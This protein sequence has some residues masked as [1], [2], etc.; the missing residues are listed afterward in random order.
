MSGA[1]VTISGNSGPGPGG[2]PGGG[3]GG[4]GGSGGTNATESGNSTPPRPT[5]AWSL[6]NFLPSEAGCVSSQPGGGSNNPDSVGS[7]QNLNEND[8][9][10]SPLMPGSPLMIKNE[11]PP[12]EED[13][14]SNSS[15]NNET[16]FVKQEPYPSENSTS[17]PSGAGIP[18]ATPS[19]ALP[20]LNGESLPDFNK[21]GDIK[22][23]LDLSSPAK[24]PEKSPE[25]DSND[26]VDSVDENEV[27][28]ALLKVKELQNIQPL[29]GI[30]D[31]DDNNVQQSALGLLSAGSGSVG[32]VPQKIKRKRKVNKTYQDRERDQQSSSSDDDG[33]GSSQR[34]RSQS[35][36]KD[37]VSKGR[38]RPRKNPPTTGGS[39]IVGSSSARQSDADSVTSNNS[40]RRLSISSTKTVASTPSKKD[41]PST[42][43]KKTT[44]RRRPSKANP[45][46]SREVLTT[47]DD[48]DAEPMRDRKDDTSVS[49]KGIRS[50]P[51]KGAPNMLVPPKPP[52]EVDDLSSDSNPEYVRRRCAHLKTYVILPIR[53]KSLFR[54]FQIDIPSEKDH[55]H[56]ASISAIFH[57]Q[58]GTEEDVHFDFGL[59][60]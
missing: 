57:F 21:L 12:M 45:K 47:T 3:G 6:V 60:R 20:G 18:T 50:S 48:S 15:S 53:T 13:H 25:K 23:D 26:Q 35:F 31:I 41:A 42:P 9:S 22:N 37:K 16:V 29:S 55:N 11:P 27:S 10:C 52:G 38:G 33:I 5:A 24:S 46:P 2:G 30:S 34:S 59:D 51:T 4:G 8:N 32:R 19:S 56:I 44:S 14:L 58:G 39:S 28:S 7:N 54:F 49:S 40:K 1:G 17:S 43:A 36:E